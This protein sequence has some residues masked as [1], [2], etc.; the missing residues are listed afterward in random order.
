[1]NEYHDAFRLHV[2]KCE[3][4]QKLML[5]RFIESFEYNLQTGDDYDQAILSIVRFADEAGVALQH[6]S[7]EDFQ[8]AMKSN[9]SFVL[10]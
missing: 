7:F 4:E 6:V 3:K 10:R 9:D 8:T 5:D 2:A 1:M